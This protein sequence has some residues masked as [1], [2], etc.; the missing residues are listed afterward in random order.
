MERQVGPGRPAG[1]ESQETRDR[2]LRAARAC[3]AAHG[4]AAT[5]T[6][7]LCD[8]AGL[9]PTAIY[10]HY[11]KKSDLMIAVYRDT[12]TA[13]YK[14]MRAAVDA[15]E[16]FT[17]KV[18]GLLEAIHQTLRDDPEQIIFAAVVQDEA[19]R[20]EELR[21]IRDDRTFEDLYAEIV[22]F[23]VKEGTVARADASQVQGALAAMALGLGMLGADT[24]VRRH[25]VITRGSARLFAG[26]L[27]LDDSDG[28]AGES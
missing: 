3:F 12:Y 14:R 2:L 17:G 8:R 13:H 24:T 15:A 7:M 21:E 19:R 20:H 28:E 11:G 18:V 22:S 16:T 6:R 9:T 1:V 26:S 27:F 5:T 4:Y 23:G 10:H 25:A